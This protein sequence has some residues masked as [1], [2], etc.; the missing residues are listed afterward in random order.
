MAVALAAAGAAW[1]QVT[2]ADY[3]RSEGLRE[4][5]M[6]L[7]KDVAD[8]ARVRVLKVMTSGI[9]FFVADIRTYVIR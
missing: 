7:T 1:G 4:S 2:P 6:Y 9:S 5:W 8:P 3:A